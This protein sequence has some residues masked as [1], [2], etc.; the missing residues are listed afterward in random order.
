MC[1]RGDDDDGDDDD[2]DYIFPQQSTDYFQFVNLTT[3]QALSNRTL[4]NL[5]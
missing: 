2:D 5:R 3:R 4:L 1:S